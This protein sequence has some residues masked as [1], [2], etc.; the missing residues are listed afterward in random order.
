MKKNLFALSPALLIALPWLVAPAYSAPPVRSVDVKSFDVAG[1]KTGMSVEEA[2]AAMQKNFGVSADK[3]RA[4]ES[5]KNQYA[6]IITGSPQI[7]HLVYENNGTRM[8]VNFQPRIPYNK[9]NPMAAYLITYEIPWTKENE[10]AMKE[11]AIAKYGPISSGGMNPVWCEK[12]LP[13]SGM[14]CETNT[15]QL[16]VGS[17][18]LRLFDPA[19]QNAATEYM[20]QQKATKPQ[21]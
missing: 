3:I 1:V 4:S 7:Q 21:F 19:W 13:T 9:A 16:T 20:A 18:S 15:A 6:T 14:G 17:T 10:K 5:M 8:Q 12:P 2:R 11:A